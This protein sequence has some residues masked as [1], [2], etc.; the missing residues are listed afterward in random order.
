MNTQ[1]NKYIRQLVDRWYAGYATPDEQDVLIHYFEKTESDKLPGD[2]AEDAMVFRA[3]GLRRHTAVDTQLLAEIDTAIE[4]EKVR[5]INDNKP[6]RTWFAIWGA[7]G[8]AACITVI[9]VIG[10]LN[11]QS[12][13]DAR[14]TT[15]PVIANNLPKDFE[16]KTL[17]QVTT[18]TKT[19]IDESQDIPHKNKVEK[20]STHTNTKVKIDIETTCDDDIIFIDDPAKGA[21]LL[22]EVDMRIQNIKMSTQTALNRS[23]TSIPDVPEYIIKDLPKI[24]KIIQQARSNITLTTI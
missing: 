18:E 12:I 23:E 16:K 22:A 1:D 15:T 5:S 9:L 3:L 14:K 11:P 7:V 20:Q 2:M 8:V 4:A 10:L 17:S 19:D 24:E 13:K 21:A 6:R